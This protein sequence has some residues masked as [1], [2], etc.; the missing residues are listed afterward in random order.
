[1]AERNV[2]LKTPESYRETSVPVTRSIASLES[3]LE[4]FGCETTST[5][6]VRHGKQVGAEVRFVYEGQ[7][8]S[9]W[10]DLGEDPKDHRQKMRVLYWGVKAMLE[11]VAFGVVTAEEVLLPFAEITDGKG[12]RTTV[13]RALTRGGGHLPSASPEGLMADLGMKA[14]PLVGEVVGDESERG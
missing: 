9:V 11:M 6:M 3:I 1:M 14:L 7:T 5:A 4:Q 2:V 12:G 8:Y 13:G 10:I